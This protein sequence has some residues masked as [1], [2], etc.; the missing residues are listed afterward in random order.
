MARQS[1]RER[2]LRLRKKGMS[3][4]QIRGVFN[5]S[6]STLSLWLHNHPLSD[7][8]LRELRDW[9][10]IRIERFRITMQKKKDDRLRVAYERQR[11]TLLPITQKELY[12]AGLMLYWGEGAKSK[13]SEVA[14]SNS[15]PAILRFFLFWLQQC[16]SVPRENVRISL[17]LYKDMDM[18]RELSF[19]STTLGIPRRQFYKPYIKTSTTKRVLF[20]GGFGHGTCNVRVNS[21]A[22]NNQTLMGIKAISDCVDKMSRKS[23]PHRTSATLVGP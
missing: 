20:K 23:Y 1:E 5:V 18:E 13:N 9:S 22:L 16:L 11:K 2:A 19:W 3:Y 6:K 14:I 4:S 8:R 15:N 17:H 21:V 10:K 12:V 7:K